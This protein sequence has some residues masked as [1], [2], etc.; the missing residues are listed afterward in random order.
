VKLTPLVIDVDVSQLGWRPLDLGGAE[1]EV[2]EDQQGSERR[3]RHLRIAFVVLCAIGLLLAADLQRVHVKV[4]T[5]PDYSS[6]C[7][8]SEEIDCEAVAASEKSVVAGLPVATWG[9]VFYLLI[10]AGA[11]LG[12]RGHRR[13]TSWPY[14]LLTLAT[15]LSVAG[16][17]WLYYLSHFVIGSICPVCVGTYLCNLALFVVALLE[18]R[19]TG[20]TPWG[21]LREDL[22]AFAST[23]GP[24]V[25]LTLA[26][27]ALVVALLQALPPYWHV[28][29]TSEG[30]GG[31]PVGRTVDGHPFIGAASPTLEIV[32]YSDYQCPHCLRGHQAMRQLVQQ[33][34]DKVRLV[35]RHFPLDQ[36][37]NPSIN[38]PFHLDACKYA[39][40][41]FCAGEQ[42]RFW[43]ANDYLFERGSRKEPVDAAELARALALDAALLATCA[44]GDA[45]RE[46][47]RRDLRAGAALGIRG[48]PTF[49]VDGQVHRGSVPPEVIAEALGKD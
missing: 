1:A 10:G 25:G 48:T 26:G 38:R 37:C 42:Q 44:D 12:F 5:D 20:R 45:A 35:H 29:L 30:P 3:G 7:S 43:E 14:G 16:S 4:H 36:Q 31:L 19:R 17:A 49:V 46:E 27:G 23:P 2:V 34:P 22:G 24:A 21:A 9:L 11:L 15:L 41:T 6:Y 13:T 39:R 32:E 28:A 33:H 8:V 18:L 47:A 40:L